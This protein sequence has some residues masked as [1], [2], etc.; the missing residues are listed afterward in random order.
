MTIYT[1]SKYTID[2]MERDVNNCKSNGCKTADN[3]PVSNKEDRVRLDELC[4][5]IPIKCVICLNYIY[6]TFFLFKLMLILNRNMC[7]VIKV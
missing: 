5:I 4:P 6:F 3:K 1:D 7:L 2:C